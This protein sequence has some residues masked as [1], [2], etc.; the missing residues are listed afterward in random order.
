[1]ID[2]QH[3]SATSSAALAAAKKFT[4]KIPKPEWAEWG[5]FPWNSDELA[6]DRAAKAA[7]R[8]ALGQDEPKD[9]QIAS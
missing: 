4:H 2:R 5:E 6:A 7:A 1:M 9:G 8:A 3:A